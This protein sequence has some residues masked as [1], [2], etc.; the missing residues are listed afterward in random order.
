[1]SKKLSATKLKMAALGNNMIEAGREI[2]INP[3]GKD[4]IKASK[5]KKESK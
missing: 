1:M 4:E 2:Y 5:V 3:P